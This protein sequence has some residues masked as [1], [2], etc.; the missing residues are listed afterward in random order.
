MNIGIINTGG[1]IS[2]VGDPLAP[3]SAS[4][5][6]QACNVWI[7]PVIQAEFPEIQLHYLVDVVFPGS[8]THTLDSTNLQPS[9][10]C[11]MAEAI[12]AHYEEMDGFVVLHGT[13]SMDFSGAA[14]S[15][16][17][18]G[19]NER[20]VGVAVLSKPVIVTGSQVPL[21]HQTD[22]MP[23][24]LNFNTDAYQNLCGAI[25]AA[26]TGIAE[27][28]VYF[29]NRLYRGNRVLKTNASEFNAFES[30]NYPY[31]AEAGVAFTIENQRCL[32]GPVNHA[33]SLDNPSVRDSLR[34]QINDLSV[35]MNT[36]LVSQLNAFPA[37][38]RIAPPQAFLAQ[39]VDA[40]VSAG[41]RGIILESYGEGNFPS[42]SPDEPSKGA[43]YQALAAA[44][45]Q[46]VILV[47]ASQVI[48]GTVNNSAYAAGAWLPQVGV[49]SSADMTPMAGLVKLTVLLALEKLHGWPEGTVNRLFQTNWAGEM[50]NTNRLDSRVNPSLLPGEHLMTFDGMA[51]LHNDPNHGPRLVRNSDNELLWQLPESLPTE[52]LPGTLTMQND[53]NL[54]FYSR[55][56]VPLWASQTG[57]SSGAASWL[58]LSG[59]SSTQQ[60]AEIT[61]TVYNYADQHV[62]VQ[63]YP[64]E[65]S[66][67]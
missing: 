24:Q 63:L 10:W 5:F 53:G 2:C 46:G 29:Q 4:A 56:Q 61:L 44:H 16:L 20:G 43:I 49:V 67:S 1:T 48:A 60:L 55:D 64:S 58:E 6:A 35:Q 8:S 26:R 23:C 39:I 40:L 3:M 33:F 42:G 65:R 45:Q 34:A 59:S 14:L 12:L 62:S 51:S 30:P 13:D 52:A 19:L 37:P 32:P 17:L 47:D 22:G 31:L 66:H 21:F 11:I 28:G 7:D 25:A 15:F 36:S 41:T 50:Q 54:V 9:D 27:V 18:N 57:H 38:Y